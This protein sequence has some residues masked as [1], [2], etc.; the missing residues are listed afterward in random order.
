MSTVSDARELMRKPEWVPAERTPESESG[1][2]EGGLTMADVVRVMKQR[3]V[4]LVT[5]FVIL[6]VLIGLITLVVWRW[7]PAYPAEALLQLHPPQEEAYQFADPLVAPDMMEVR[8]QT[9]ARKIKRPDVIQD[10]FGLPEVR[11][12][13]YY[14]WYGSHEK[15]V[16]DAEDQIR[17]TPVPDTMLIMVRLDARDKNDARLIV[18]KLVERYVDRYSRENKEGGLTAVET[19]KATRDKVKKDLLD[20]QDELSR[21]RAQTDVGALES[22]TMMMAQSISD[23][24][25][26]VN[27]YDAHAAELEAQIKVMSGTDPASLPI[28]PEDRVIVEADPLL[29]LYRQQVESLDVQIASMKANTLGG[30]NKYV[31]LLNSQRD[32]YLRLETT[33]REELF[34]DLRERKFQ[35]VK[36]QQIRVR[37]VQARVQE[38]LDELEARLQDLD[39]A[40]VRYENMVKDEERY[41][42]SLADV[43]EKL[44]G[45]EHSAAVAPREG[46]LSVVQPPTLA[47][48]PSRPNLPLYLGGGFVLALAGAVGLVFLRE[49]TDKYIRT[50]IDVAR[51]GRLSVLG[52]VP[53][54][55]DEEAE[56]DAIEHA[57]RQAPHSLTAESFRQIRANLMFSGPPESQ[58]V[59]LITSPGPG[60]G[61]TAVAINLAT[62]LAQG[63]ERVLLVDCNFRRPAL[64]QAFPG[65]RAEGLSNLLIGQGKL[66]QLVT[67]TNVPKLDVLTSG[68]M[69]PTPAELLGSAYMREL[70]KEARTRYDR[71]LFDGPPVLLVSDALI[72]ATQVD[73]VIL[74]ARASDNTKGVLRRAREQLQRIQAHIA[75]AVVNGVRARPGGYYRQQYREFYEYGADE[76]VPPELPGPVSPDASR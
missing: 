27:T 28:T 13:A 76:T 60:N 26:L 71:V 37:T 12:T 72:T 11:Q 18:Q 74:V 24:Q 57:A 52:V 43:E 54:L 65:T 20:K 50:P 33:R 64:R 25:Y 29:R 69:P 10:V 45:F 34:D 42:K 17:V 31:R 61:K 19:L 68:P 4:L 47:V 5:T 56:V 36:E 58:Q 66:D 73:S 41:L 44:L 51:H 1:A 46:R 49:V 22:E 53:E 48:W 62:T 16:E 14:R 23:Q 67:H 9:E 7:F 55:E 30:K 38:Q 35:S 70:I 40:R 39:A 59:L 8:V 15:A 75:G 32:G 2:P 6:Y 63:G 3:K 21:F